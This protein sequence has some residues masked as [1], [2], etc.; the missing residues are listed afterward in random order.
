MNERDLAMLRRSVERRLK[1]RGQ[2]NR[3]AKIAV[4]KMTIAELEHATR[5]SLLERVGRLFA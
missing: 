2:S 1:A 5:P 3:D 4:A